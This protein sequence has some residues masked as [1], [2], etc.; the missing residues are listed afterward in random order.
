MENEKAWFCVL[1]FFTFVI[2]NRM[3]KKVTYGIEYKRFTQVPETVEQ[4]FKSFESLSKKGRKVE[5]AETA[6]NITEWLLDLIDESDDPE[7]PEIVKH[8]PKAIQYSIDAAKLLQ[9]SGDTELLPRYRPTNSFP[10]SKVL[11]IYSYQ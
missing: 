4:H 6:I 11:I 2:R 5:A 10:L 8:F 3:G 9:E 7:E 1:T